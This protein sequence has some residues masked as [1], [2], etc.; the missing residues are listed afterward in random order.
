MLALDA[1]DAATKALKSAVSAGDRATAAYRTAAERIVDLRLA[2]EDL[3]GTG[4]S[5]L[6]ARRRMLD[7]AGLTDRAA[8]ARVERNLRYHVGEVLAA[9]GLRP[10]S[11]SRRPDRRAA[12]PLAL[13]EKALAVGRKL[14]ALVKAPGT[15]VPGGVL[16]TLDELAAVLAQVRRAVESEGRVAA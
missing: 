15:E 16:D 9:R 11:A 3:D 1:E 4:A 5:Y 14:L 7:G 12:D 8:A 10:R 2:L 13:V 6:A